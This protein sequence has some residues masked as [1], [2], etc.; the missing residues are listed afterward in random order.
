MSNPSV[1][2]PSVIIRRFDPTRGD[3]RDILEAAC[4][5]SLTDKSVSTGDALVKAISKMVNRFSA[6]D[7]GRSVW[8]A[9]EELSATDLSSGRRSATLGCVGIW[10]VAATHV[11]R[12]HGPFAS[13]QFLY[14]DPKFPVL[15]IG[16]ALLQRI[17]SSGGSIDGT[18]YSSVQVPQFGQTSAAMPCYQAEGFKP[19]DSPGGQ[20][21][22]LFKLTDDYSSEE[23]PTVAEALKSQWGWSA[24]ETEHTEGGLSGKVSF[25]IRKGGMANAAD[26]DLLRRAQAH[27]KLEAAEIND[28]DTLHPDAFQKLIVDLDT[29]IALWSVTGSGEER[30]AVWIADSVTE[31]AEGEERR[32]P[33]ACIG[34]RTIGTAPS[35]KSWLE[36]LYV[37][38]SIDT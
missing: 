33:N 10:R 21:G 25:D 5:H 24:R 1:T 35:A 36:A 31:D 8:V 14:V 22:V 30:R 17:T 4:T 26:V 12:D 3:D 20:T 18:K 32:T 23:S 11:D 7:D 19:R 34:V 28:T 38:P 27:H 29:E 6:T 37:A 9:E 13:L 2:S 15:D 16:C